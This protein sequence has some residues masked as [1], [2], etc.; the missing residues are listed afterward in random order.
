ML[1]GNV[2]AAH[3]LRRSFSPYWRRNL[4]VDSDISLHS[5]GGAR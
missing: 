1:Q 5:T 2:A 4:D 3:E